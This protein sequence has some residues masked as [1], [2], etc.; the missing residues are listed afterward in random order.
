MKKVF[1]LIFLWLGTTAVNA[2]YIQLH[3]SGNVMYTNPISSVDSIHFSENYALFNIT[4]AATSLN[5]QK[6]YID[7][8]TFVNTPV[9]TNKIYIIYNGAE[10]A[11]IINPYA[12]QGLTISAVGGKVTATGATG[13]SNLEYNLLGSSST[14]SLTLS[15]T[16]AATFVLNNLNITNSS[17]P[18]ILITG[19][20][21]H[22][23]TSVAGTTNSLSD[24]TSSTKNGAL[25]A[26]GK[27]IFSGSGTLTVTGVKKHGI[28]SSSSIQI[29]SSSITINNA[30]SD[31][32]HSEGFL[33][34]GGSLNIT[35]STSDGIDAGDGAIVISD[36]TIQVNSSSN[37]VKAIKTGNSTINL[38]GGVFQLNVAGN[39]SKAISAKGAIG[40]TGGTY[41]IQLGGAV[42]LSA[43]GSG[44]D[45]SYCSAIK[46]DAT[47]SIGGG[48]FTIN[49]AASA[50]GAKGFSANGDLLLSGGTFTITTLGGSGSYVNISGLPDSYSTTAF[51]SDT[52]IVVSGG[53]YTLVNSGNEGKAFSSDGSIE[54][55]SGSINITNNAI[56]GKGFKADGNAVLSGGTITVNLS[57]ATLLNTLGSGFDPSYP[58]AIK[59]NGTITV[60]SGSSISVIASS[61][62]TGAKGLSADNG[63]LINDGTININLAGD[64]GNYTDSSGLADSYSAAALNSDTDIVIA[65]GILTLINSG[66]SGKNVN[67]DANIQISGGVLN[68]TNSGA[69]GKGFNADQNLTI[70]G[71]TATINL[72]GATVLTASGSGYDPSYPTGL[73]ADGSIF[74][75]AGTITITGASSGSGARGLSADQNIQIADGTIHIT[76][77]GN[78]ANYTNASGLSDSYGTAA[79][80]A[81]SSI[82]IV[83]G[84]ITTQSSGTGGKGLKS[85]GSITIGST[86]GNPTIQLTTTG[87]RFLVSG[88]DY[89]HPK[90]MVATGPIQILNGSITANSSDDGIHSDSMITISGGDHHITASSATQGVGEGIEAPKIYFTGGVTHVT[91]SNDGINATYGTVAGGTE[92]NDHSLLNISG[93]ILVVAGTDAIDSNGDITISGGTTIV[94]GPTNQPEEG[95]DFNGTFL[96]NGGF[97][98]SAG[99][100]SNMTKA[101]SSSSAQV[102]MYIKSSAQLSASSLLHIENASGTEMVTFKP[103]N[104]VYYFHFSSS[105]LARSTQYKIYFG[106]SYSGG[107]FIGNSSG[108]GLYSGGT[109]SL[110]GATLKSTFTTSA[111][112]NVNTIS[113]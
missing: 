94:C 56:A 90:T 16:T 45:P 46:S 91:A 104:A 8:M 101:M 23:F 44:Y 66:A 47:I 109:Y 42:I 93:G 54:V 78:G 35:A 27:M 41:S 77:A 55:T 107:A 69:A 12:S 61:S 82:L 39:A 51:T 6:M 13:I 83:G 99:S 49:T 2:Q 62:A 38:S 73:K 89:C 34:S 74:V 21:A 80:S 58:T 36:G 95:L 70:S 86:T 17:G 25:Q 113:F 59:A 97:L 67:S 48:N 40:I 102:S 68:L 11:T 7:S 111:S 85:D 71:G 96:M 106:G 24:G 72:S 79:F 19:G 50:N 64:G 37:D 31:G 88:T 3:N 15:S 28:Y 32:L 26:D 33:M 92:S 81:D 75:T 20:Q 98:I 4:G 65:G 1:F 29:L 18:A 10:N 108:W 53:N 110:S 76:I 52:R 60:L 87:A 30:A 57:G 100:N 9:T 5:I 63:I 43:S 103:K 22:T 14:G 112:S 105:A 84:N